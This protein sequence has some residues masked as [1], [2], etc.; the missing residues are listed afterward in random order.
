MS[1]G[2]TAPQ[3]WLLTSGGE[4]RVGGNED[5]LSQSVGRRQNAIRPFRVSAQ[6]EES[7][8]GEGVDYVFDET[9][10]SF[11][12]RLIS[13]PP[14]RCTCWNIATVA[15]SPRRS[16][17]VVFGKYASY[18]PRVQDTQNHRPFG[19]PTARCGAVSIS[20]LSN[21]GWGKRKG[22]ARGCR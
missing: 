20:Q 14:Y 7:N 2:P 1:K 11:R 3:K 22:T 12:M 17:R 6:K 5:G 19:I 10:S 15:T 16:F 18:F 21:W 8:P 9:E 13:L 4:K